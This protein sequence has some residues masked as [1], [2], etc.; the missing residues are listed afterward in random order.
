MTLMTISTFSS[1]QKTFFLW[2]RQSNAFRLISWLHERHDT[3]WTGFFFTRFWSNCF[4]HFPNSFKG[5]LRLCF[6]LLG[7]GKIR[8][9]WKTPTPPDSI[10]KMR[11]KFKIRSF[12]FN[13]P[14]SRRDR[15]KKWIRRIFW[16]LWM[17]VNTVESSPYLFRR[18]I[19]EEKR[20]IFAWKVHSVLF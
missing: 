11:F 16:V 12:F 18:N 1:L 20:A 15:R 7:F 10:V 9:V 13:S 19:R 6:F 5:I 8:H 14:K 17:D 4:P 3:W 2:N